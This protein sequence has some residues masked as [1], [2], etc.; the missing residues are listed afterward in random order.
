LLLEALESL[1]LRCLLE[2]ATQPLT[3]KH[4]VSFTQQPVVMEYVTER[5]IEQ[6]CQEIST[7]ETVFFNRYALMK[8][9]AK[10]YL[11][12]AQLRLI[13]QP[14]A[15]RLLAIFGNKESY[16][17]LPD[18][19]FVEVANV[20]WNC[21]GNAWFYRSIT[22]I[23]KTRICWRKCSQSLLAASDRPQ[24]CGFLLPNCLASLP[25]GR[26]FASRQF[27]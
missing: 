13:L 19:D 5:L 12:D 27:Y 18:S 22:F 6:V 16:Q 23:A 20:L 21:S 17:K 11:R 2:K 9:Q 24:Q 10:D 4:S 26:E 7:G 8:A 25:S 1:Q 14:I 3:Q 15:D